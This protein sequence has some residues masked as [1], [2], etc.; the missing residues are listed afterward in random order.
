MRFARTWSNLGW[1][2]ETF[3]MDGVI[4]TI[5]SAKPV[6]ARTPNVKK[7][8][9]VRRLV[10]FMVVLLVVWPPLAWL[11]ARALIVS[12]DLPH[13]DALVV[14]GGS[15]TYME[16]TQ[17]AAKAFREGR[18]AKII[19]TNDGRQGGW[20]EEEQRNPLFVE[21]ALKELQREGVP[22]EKIEIVPRIVSSTYEEAQ[23]IREYA[24]AH[25]IQ[26]LLIITSA[27][28]SRRAHWTLRRVF[29][30]TG[31]AIGSEPAD[32]GQQTPSPF[33]WWL[34]PAGWQMVAG[35]YIK[36]AYYRMKY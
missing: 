1:Q 18:A 14:L 2:I 33:V 26:S 12:E 8:A 19:L 24:I 3:R 27:Y 16:R 35:E 17:R 34:R 31:I 10:Q 5:E 30:G 20:S 21:R 22:F 13:A 7:R 15:A 32:T 6:V 4:E 25:H 29:D 36:L 9:R 11:A 23:L 28:H